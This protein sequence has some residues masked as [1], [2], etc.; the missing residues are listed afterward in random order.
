MDANTKFTDEQEV[1]ELPPIDKNGR[2]T[3]YLSFMILKLM[4]SEPNRRFTPHHLAK[5]L[6]AKKS[7]TD[8]ICRQ[9]KQLDLLSEDPLQ[10]VRYQYNLN[11]SNLEIQTALECFLAEV[12]L[13]NLPVHLMLDYS[14]SFH[15]LAHSHSRAGRF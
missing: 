11:T 5:L 4:F 6:A 15:S 9:L 7:D 12:E 14:P 2:P 3:T 8:L 13:N 10:T 1:A